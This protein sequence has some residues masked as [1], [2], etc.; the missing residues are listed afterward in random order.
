MAR[1]VVQEILND[2]NHEDI[3]PR[4]RFRD[5]LN[6]LDG[7][8]DGDIYNRYRFP[9]AVIFDLIE[10]LKDDIERPTRKSAA[11]TSLQQVCCAL[12]YLASNSFQAVVGDTLHFSKSATNT[13]IWRVISAIV[14]RSSQFIKFPNE[15]ELVN[16]KRGFFEK[17]NFPN[18]VGLIDGT[19]IKVIV[20]KNIEYVFVNRK[21]FHSINVQVI[22]FIIFIIY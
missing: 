5:H 18:V 4:K 13:A 2:E 3:I 12:R 9:P 10:L 11:L 22:L 17:A 20:P 15:D 14:R 16:V 19:H 7:Y 21:S 6:P 1:R 8:S